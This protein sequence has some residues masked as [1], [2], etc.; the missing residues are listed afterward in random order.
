MP[1]SQLN[2][3]GNNP[4]FKLVWWSR[5]ESLFIS[6]SVVYDNIT[7]RGFH[8]YLLI[9]LSQ[10][11]LSPLF[12]QI[13]Y[14]LHLVHHFSLA[15]IHLL[16]GAQGEHLVGT[17]L[18]VAVRMHISKPGKYKLVFCITSTMMNFTCKDMDRNTCTSCSSPRLPVQHIHQDPQQPDQQGKFQPQPFSS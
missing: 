13:H 11:V 15:L 1:Q 17:H 9:L 14:L 16:A 6:L 10:Q 7:F 8:Q 3:A 2:I 18:H 12:H 5:N 4:N